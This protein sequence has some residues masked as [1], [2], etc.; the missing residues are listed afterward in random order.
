MSHDEGSGISYC[1]D[2]DQLFEN[3]N[4]H[5]IPSEWRLF[6]DSSVNSLVIV[7]LHIGNKFPSVPI[8]YTRSTAE[9]YEIIKLLLDL[10]NYNEHQWQVCCD[11]KVVG[12]LKGL[13]RGFSK[14]QCFLCTWEGRKRELHYTNYQ[15][16]SRTTFQIGIDSI[17]H[18][19]LIPSS[20]IILPPLHIKLGMIRNFLVK[21]DKNGAAFKELAKI[22]PKLS[23][24]KI[25]AGNSRKEKHYYQ[26]CHG[27]TSLS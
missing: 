11:L 9:T 1:C 22:F 27:F 10:I 20:K 14:H 7:L 24:A 13:K 26:F 16:N 12:L 18:I 3:L 23:T 21:L 4:H 8:G 25:S 2:V 5:H 6:I 17:D 15:W 19:P